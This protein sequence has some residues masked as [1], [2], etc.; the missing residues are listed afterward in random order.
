[1]P[2]IRKPTL[3]T[4]PYDAISPDALRGTLDGLVVAITGAGGGLGR[5]ESLAFAQAGAKLALIDLEQAASALHSTTEQCAAL[6]AQAKA[7]FCNVIDADLSRKTWEQIRADLGEIDVLVNNA[8]GTIDRPVHMETFDQFWAMID[9]NFKAPMLWT[10]ML[11][12]AFRARGHGRIINIAS[13]SATV[14]LPFSAN[15]AAAKAA[16]VRANGCIQLELDMDGF[17]EIEIYSLHPGATKTGIQKGLSS[18]IAAVYPKAAAAYKSFCAQFKCEPALCGQT[19]V[20]LAAGRG[21]ALKGRYLDCEQDI[22]YVVS[23]GDHVREHGLYEL[24][25]DFLGGLPNDG[26]T[27]PDAGIK[28]A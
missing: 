1:M 26:G 8:G 19:C 5:G 22:G 13:R 12:P 16:L 7:Y 24:K 10:H 6:G 9:L 4:K 28:E 23:M 2:E 21:T 3:H 20:F 14:N 27:M 15:Y 25:V 18:D 17:D 11:L